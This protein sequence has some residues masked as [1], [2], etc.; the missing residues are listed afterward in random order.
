MSVP[1]RLLPKPQLVV[2]FPLSVYLS[3]KTMDASVLHSRLKKLQVS[4][5]THSFCKF[6]VIIMN[7]TGA[8][9]PSC[10]SPLGL[11]KCQC[12]P[13]LVPQV[14]FSIEVLCACAFMCIFECVC[15]LYAF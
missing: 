3:A 14:V 6:H 11:Y 9:D 10:T 2:S 1:L 7:L 15:V 12:R 5:Q 8:V 13:P 4:E